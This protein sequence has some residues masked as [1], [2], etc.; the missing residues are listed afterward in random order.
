MNAPRTATLRSAIA[1][2]TGCCHCD[3]TET[4]VDQVLYLPHFNEIEARVPL[5]RAPA[6]ST[7]QPVCKYDGGQQLIA[8][9]SNE[10]AIR[11]EGI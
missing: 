2:P 8:P 10:T 7:A 3:R 6:S 1:K 4:F 11:S 5:G 9:S